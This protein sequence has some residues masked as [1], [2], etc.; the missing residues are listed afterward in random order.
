MDT[1]RIER[2][3]LRAIQFYPMLRDVSTA[4]GYALEGFLPV[5]RNDGS[6]ERAFEIR[7]EFTH[8]YPFEFPLVFELGNAL[9]HNADWH[10]YGFSGQCCLMPKVQELLKCVNSLDILT[11]MEE[12]VVSYFAIQS[13]R[14]TN[15]F[16]PEG[17][18]RHG[19]L[20]ILQAYMDL[21]KVKDPKAVVL[22][23]G[24]VVFKKTPSYKSICP[25]CSRKKFGDCHQGIILKLMKIEGQVARDLKLICPGYKRFFGI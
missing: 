4:A 11:F 13:F 22:A 25:I 8:S 21:L 19:A 7:M 12:V 14:L 24:M 17:E 2:D 20:G 5:N 6:L 3:I 9:I 15:G 18:Y 10:F 16:Y 23:L 1:E